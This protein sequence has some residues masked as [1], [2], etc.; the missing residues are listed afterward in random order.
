MEPEERQFDMTA[1]EAASIL[2]VTRQTIKNMIDAGKLKGSKVFD[3][4]TNVEVWMVDSEEV[5]AAANQ[6]NSR[7]VAGYSKE[8]QRQAR[9]TLA[10]FFGSLEDTLKE[11]I[12]IERERLGVDRDMVEEIKGLREEVRQR[13]ALD[14]ELLEEQRKSREA[15][16]SVRKLK[17]GEERPGWLARLASCTPS[18][19][20]LAGYGYRSEVLKSF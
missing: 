16:E 20:R 5:E 18:G 2:G 14:R 15:M 13:M 6:K 4:S 3:A 7:V 12:E 8:A 19:S 11:S 10:G 17:E 1:R 9:E